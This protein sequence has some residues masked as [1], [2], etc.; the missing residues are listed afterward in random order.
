MEH[1]T[2]KQRATKFVNDHPLMFT[3]DKDW[4]IGEIGLMILQ[5]ERAQLEADRIMTLRVIGEAH[6]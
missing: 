6:S 1:P 4:W 5:A 2:A 3:Q